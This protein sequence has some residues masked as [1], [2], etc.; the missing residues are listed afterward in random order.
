MP[1][2]L[3]TF[4]LAGNRNFLFGSDRTDS[5]PKEIHVVLYNLSAHKTQAVKKFLEQNPQVR[6]HF[7]PTYSS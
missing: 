5:T 1:F 7:I 4:Y 3:G 2:Q 6:F